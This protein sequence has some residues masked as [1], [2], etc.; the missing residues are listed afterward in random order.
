MSLLKA[1]NTFLNKITTIF[2][3]SFNKTDLEF[4]LELLTTLFKILNTIP[5]INNGGCLIS[6]MS[7]ILYMRKNHPKY[8]DDF[9]IIQ[10]GYSID[11]YTT[12]KEAICNN[13]LE[14][15]VSDRHF[16]I[17]VSGQD[18][19]YFDSLGKH[20]I[21]KFV[22]SLVIPNDLTDEF[23]NKCIHYH[24]WN[25]SFNRVTQVPIIEKQFNIN[26]KQYGI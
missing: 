10:L 22:Y 1:L 15:C 5:F 23:F 6:A 21:N 11:S 12:N 18:D 13:E 3:R 20:I 26:L 4:K 7:V 14:T 2:K 17:V 24:K 9:S 16:A 8:A 25:S 19:V